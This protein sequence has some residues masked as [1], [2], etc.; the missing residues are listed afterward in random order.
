MAAR[1]QL[2]TFACLFVLLFVV[3]TSCRATSV[4]GSSGYGDGTTFAS[5]VTSPTNCEA[6]SDTTFSVNGQT[7]LQFVFNTGTG[8]GGTVLDLVDLGSIGPGQTFSLSSQYFGAGTTEVF[9]C[10]GASNPTGGS[11]VVESSTG[12]L[13]APGYPSGGPCT[14]VNSGTD[15]T[16]TLSGT[17]SSTLSFKTDSGFDVSGDFVVDS[18]VPTST[19]PVP[20]PSTLML[21][22]VGL[23]AVGR[24]LRSHA[25]R[26]SSN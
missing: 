14:T 2:T 23:F 10:G 6:F 20:E 5:C 4:R 19:A 7:V 18:T 15:Y 13:P 26:E 12:A 22:G 8:T 24:K 21:T 17:T 16:F 9:A 3:A 11:G 25:N 1:R